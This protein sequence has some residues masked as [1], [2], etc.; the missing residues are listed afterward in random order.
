[1]KLRPEVLAIMNKKSILSRLTM[2]EE[3]KY[4]DSPLYNV[5]NIIAKDMEYVTCYKCKR[6][7]NN[8]CW[9]CEKPH[10]SK[11]AKSIFFPQ[12]RL[13]NTFCLKCCKLLEKKL[14]KEGQE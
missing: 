2:E 5:I 7:N 4:K 12:I 6:T 8:L 14:K 10:C 3:S 11:H 13:I 9:N 1:M